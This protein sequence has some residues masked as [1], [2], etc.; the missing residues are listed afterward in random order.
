[1]APCVRGFQW[2]AKVDIK[3]CFLNFPLSEAFSEYFGF[4]FRDQMY[5]FNVL[6]F[7]WSMSPYLVTKFIAP[8]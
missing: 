4:C 3:N 1:M 2:C 5:K 8:I 7:G 6:P